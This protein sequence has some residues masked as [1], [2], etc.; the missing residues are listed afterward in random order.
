M[1]A[2]SW[3]LA[4]RRLVIWGLYWIGATLI[5]KGVP[6]QFRYATAGVLFIA[7]TAIYSATTQEVGDGE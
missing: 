3:K 7:F 5:C 2:L 4:L 1:K 6:P